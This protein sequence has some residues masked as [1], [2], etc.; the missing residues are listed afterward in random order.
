M[1]GPPNGAA[2][3]KLFD[4]TCWIHEIFGDG[5]YEE[6]ILFDKIWG[7]QNKGI[8]LKHGHQNSNFLTTCTR[9]M[10]FFGINKFKLKMKYDKVWGYHNEG[11]SLKRGHQN[12]KFL[13]LTLDV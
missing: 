10:N 6:K 11:V 12:S 4:H 2:K 5:K 1:G 7:Y 8:F 13:P 3:F 9:Q